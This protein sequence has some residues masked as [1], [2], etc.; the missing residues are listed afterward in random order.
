MNNFYKRIVFLLTF[1]SIIL[2]LFIY[3]NYGSINIK[4][5][6]LKNDFRKIYSYKKQIS[7]SSYNY[8]NNRY[9]SYKYI[10]TDKTQKKLTNDIFD[11]YSILSENRILVRKGIF[12]GVVDFNGNY[13]LPLK[14]LS[15]EFNNKTN[16][17]KAVEHSQKYI[18][19]DINGKEILN[20]YN[21]V[22][23]GSYFISKSDSNNN[24]YIIYDKNIKKIASVF[25]EK[26][27]SIL[28]DKYLKLKRNKKYFLTDLFGKIIITDTK[29]NIFYFTTINDK[30][31]FKLQYNVGISSNDKEGIID[32]SNNIIIPP[33][34]NSIQ[35]YKGKTNKPLLI[36]SK[37][38][39][40]VAVNIE[41][42]YIEN[43]DLTGAP[44]YISEIFTNKK[45][46]PLEPQILPSSRKVLS[47]KKVMLKEEYI[48]L[49]SKYKEPK[50]EINNKSAYINLDESESYKT[51]PKQ[52]LHKTNYKSDFLN[53]K[54][55]NIFTKLI[56]DERYENTMCHISP[57]GLSIKY[58]G[59]QNYYIANKSRDSGKYYFEAQ[60]NTSDNEE[61]SVKTKFSLIDSPPNKEITYKSWSLSSIMK[62]HYKLKSNDIICFAID[63]D[64]NKLYI[65]INGDW[66]IMNPYDRTEGITIKDK[67]LYPAFSVAGYKETLTVNFGAQKFKYI[68]PDGYKAYSKG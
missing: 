29:Y 33:I 19:L 7:F 43:P 16:L 55:K 37:N 58:C 54:R 5:L 50:L 52:P 22:G 67:S 66:S 53:N 15:I 11:S 63:F 68:V 56:C 38:N 6:N 25:S 8:R 49:I 44:N 61:I 40:Y 1:F 18:V 36:C 48:D 20:G 31:Y 13:I 24:I 2:A 51:P 47:K 35:I 12:Y 26:R 9:K 39:L 57:N 65:A 45:E 46:K 59:W 4:Y 60:I 28:N 17:Y 41:G 42:E 30:D 62:N 27:P 3:I 32:N 64:N 14:Y 23:E 10:L 21:I 34:F